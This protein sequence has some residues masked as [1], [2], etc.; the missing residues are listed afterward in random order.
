MCGIIGIIANR[1]IACELIAGTATARI[2]RLRLGWHRD[3]WHRLALERLD[4]VL[5]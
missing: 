1:P 4:H 3:A 5:A 2:P